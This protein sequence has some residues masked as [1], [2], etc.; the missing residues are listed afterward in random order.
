MGKWK[1]AGVV[2]VSKSKKVLLL[3]IEVLEP[4]K[5]LIVDIEK[6]W[7]LLEEKTSQIP[8]FEPEK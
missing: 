8:I 6:L 7:D 4:T 1:K 2:R 5:W 3:A